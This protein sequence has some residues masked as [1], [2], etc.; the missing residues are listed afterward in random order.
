MRKA[1]LGLANLPFQEEG[2]SPL[3]EQRLAEVVVA[4]TSVVVGADESRG[5]R[6]IPLVVYEPFNRLASLVTETVEVA[7]PDRSLA[8]PPYL[9]GLPV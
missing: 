3:S 2:P 4:T 6:V 7:R 1:V 8:A 5:L 9:P